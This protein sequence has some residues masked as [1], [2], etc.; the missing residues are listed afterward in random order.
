[1][2]EGIETFDGMGLEAGRIALPSVTFPREAGAL[3]S[4]LPQ[5]ATA[6]AAF[7]AWLQSWLAISTMLNEMSASLGQPAL[8]P[9][10][11]SVKVAQKLRLVDHLVK[12]WGKGK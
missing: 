6:D 5:D 8:Y 4:V 12:V 3:P 11:V 10:V 7:V 1:M 2:V 9:Y